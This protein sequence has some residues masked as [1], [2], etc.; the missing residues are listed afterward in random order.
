MLVT[1]DDRSSP[2]ADDW[3][4]EPGYR[5]GHGTWRAA[6]E[7][8]IGTLRALLEPAEKPE[9]VPVTVVRAGE[10][11]ALPGAVEILTETGESIAAPGR[12]PAQ[13]PLGYHT[14]LDASGATS[15]LIV[16]PGRCHLPPGFRHWGW[17]IQLY[18]LRSRSSWG[19]GDLADLRRFAGWSGTQGAGIAVINPLHATRPGTPQEP[20]PYFPSSRCFY[21]PLYLRIEAIPGAE[22]AGIDLE[23][24]GAA[25]RALNSAPLIDRDTIFRLKMSAL[26]SLWAL[27]RADRGFDAFVQRSGSS[28]RDFAVYTTL[29]EHHGVP[30][31]TWPAEHRHPGSPAVARFALDHVDRIEFHQWIQWLLDEQ[32]A[33]AAHDLGLVGDLAVG[34]DPEGADAW[35]WQDSFALGATIGAPPDQFNS[36]GQDWGVLAFSPGRLWAAAYEPFIETVRAGLRHAGGL[37]FDHVMGLWRLWLVPPGAEPS[38]G[39]YV[40]YPVDDLLDILALESHRAATLVVGEDLGTVEPEVR[41]ELARRGMLSYKVLWFEGARPEDYPEQ[42]LATVTNHDLPTLPGLW[43]GADLEAQ[44]AMAL[45]PDVAGTNM[46]LERLQSWLDLDRDAP[47]DDV[48]RA[49][50]ALLGRA[51]S[52]VLTATL[53]DALGVVERP[54]QPGTTTQRPNWSLPL[55]LVLED[56][57]RLELAR[58]IALALDRSGA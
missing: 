18:A 17:A 50:Y 22:H 16:S 26:E 29:H 30:P 28:L 27:R 45:D 35:R 43:T 52:A 33:A 14:L 56:I 49:V 5:D 13:L 12:L 44:R 4:V 53:E 3:A 57:E 6:A 34:V 10:T 9:A 46:I 40:T 36:R 25:G 8:T 21:N 1:P 23:R 11:R 58:D 15:R 42:A 31:S 32:L 39:A 19:M 7:D 2:R 20:S 51:P 37:R 24:L 48:A 55:P 38:Q 47:L 41:T 54:N